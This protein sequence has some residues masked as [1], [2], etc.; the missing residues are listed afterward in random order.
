VIGALTAGPAGAAAGLITQEV[1]K[2]EKILAANYSITGTWEK[3]L[4]VK[5]TSPRMARKKRS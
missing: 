4:V 5:Q 3:P 1:L 2:G